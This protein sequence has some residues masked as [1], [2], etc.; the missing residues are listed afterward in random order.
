M[1]AAKVA[2]PHQAHKKK[3]NPQDGHLA[4]GTRIEI[5]DV[6]DQNVSDD[7]VKKSPHHVDS[8]RRKSLSGRFGERAL[9]GVTHHPADKVGN[10]IRKKRTTKKIRDIMQPF[11]RKSYLPVQKWGIISTILS[12]QGRLLTFS[13][14]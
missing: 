14:R 5:S 13:S 3:T 7:E 1:E 11:H 8:R 4:R 2:C 12:G 6:A 9:K 10:S